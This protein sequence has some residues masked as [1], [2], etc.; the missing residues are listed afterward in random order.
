LAPGDTP[1]YSPTTVEAHMRE[2]YGRT[3]KG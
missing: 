3:Y 1:K 2:M